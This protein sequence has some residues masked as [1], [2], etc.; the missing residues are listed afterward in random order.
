MTGSVYGVFE[1]PVHM[2][3]GTTMA[4]IIRDEAKNDPSRG[5][6]GG[7]EMETVSLGVPFMAAF[8]KPGGWG[9]TFTTAMEAYPRMAGMWLIGEDMPQETNRVTLDPVVKDDHG[10][11]VASVHFDDHPNDVAMRNHAY[12]QGAAV[13]DAVGA[14]T[15]FPT[16]PYPSTHNMGTNRMSE[17]PRDGVV[18][19]YGR[20]HDI[21]NLFVSDGQPV[22]LGRRL[23]SDPD[24]RRPGDPPGRPHRRFHEAA[25]RLVARLRR[26]IL[27]AGALAALPVPRF[28][29]G[30]SRGAWQP[31]GRPVGGGQ[32]D[33]LSESAGWH[34]GRGRQGPAGDPCVGP[35]RKARTG[36]QGLDG[37][38]RDEGRDAVDRLPGRAW[39]RSGRLGSRD[40]DQG[41]EVAA[42]APS[43]LGRESG[44]LPQARVLRD[45]ED[46]GAAQ[47]RCEVVNAPLMG[48][49]LVVQ[50]RHELGDARALIN[51]NFLENAPEG[52]LEADR[53]R[54]AAN[55]H[56]ARLRLVIA[57]GLV[58]EHPAHGAKS[59]KMDFL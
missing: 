29:S 31:R 8:L 3:R 32:L 22:H 26:T 19:K 30:G 52:V 1:R 4:G 16:P 14:T 10:L 28:A 51:R 58:R 13:Y 37:R 36:E 2:Y 33:R 38:C 53:R 46:A 7:Y 27:T 40:A 42:A 54:V 20:T 56:R 17:N 24:H 9:R 15:T 34:A 35:G 50:G 45:I 55:P 57:H 6:V 43:L 49:D 23:Q 41:R 25:R 21:K 48:E 11:P 5:F 59:R 39:R 44:R 12:R 47:Q 18:N